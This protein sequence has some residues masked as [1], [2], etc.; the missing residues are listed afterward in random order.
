MER[1]TFRRFFLFY[2]KNFGTRRD[3]HGEK[4][5]FAVPRKL[6][7]TA[8]TTT[9]LFCHDRQHLCEGFKKLPQC[10]HEQ[11]HFK[12]GQ[13]KGD[14]NCLDRFERRNAKAAEV[15]TQGYFWRLAFLLE[16]VILHRI[17]CA[18]DDCVI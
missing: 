15:R 14:Q 12:A 6:R 4:E 13:C 5:F 2:E 9:S 10:R 11:L 7:A 3:L 18:L 16:W 1:E 17:S 8:L